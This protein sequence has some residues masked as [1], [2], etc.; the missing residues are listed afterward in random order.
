MPENAEFSP[1]TLEIRDR[2][3]D[4]AVIQACRTWP[5]LVDLDPAP[6]TP[7]LAGVYLRCARCAQGVARLST[8]DPA[9]AT[10][11]PLPHTVQDLE[12]GVLRHVLQAHRP[13]V[14]PEW[15]GT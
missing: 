8:G 2:V 13:D 4:P 5:V 11:V 3:L 9:P 12:A 10:T 15:S 14:D 1:P 6:D 7:F